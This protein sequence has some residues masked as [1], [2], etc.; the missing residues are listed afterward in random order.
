[1][2]PYAYSSSNELTSKP[3]VTYTYDLNGNTLTSV[4]GSNNTT[5]NWDF[6]NRMTS[7]TLPGTSGSV[8]F[9]YDPMGHRIYKSSSSATSIYAYDGDNLIE[10]TN[11]TGAVVARYTQTQEID[12]PLAMLRSSAT[13]YYHADGLGSVTSLSSAVGALAQT[14]T[15]DSFGKST[16][17]SGSL[18]NPFQF[19]G[20]EFD[21]ESSLYFMRAR[22]F[23][24]ITG[25]F[26]SE[27]PARFPGGINFYTYVENDPVGL[28]DPFGFC[29]WQV[30]SRPLK[31]LPVLPHY[32]FYNTQTGQS[33]GLGPAGGISG[34]TVTGSPVPGGWERNEKPGHNE[35]AVPDGACNCVDQKAKHPGIPPNYCTYQG[36]K[37]ANPHPPCTNCLGWVLSVL[38]DC[39]NQ[40]SAGQQ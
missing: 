4:T 18:T 9:K 30:H 38:Q 11:A 12:E 3:G 28:V 20:R 22:Y 31:G 2:S 35:G 25:R 6:E 16:A 1:M 14:Y 34:G 27:D 5:Y 21:T 24:Q 13:S 23:D 10:E 15:F 39:Y 37:N 7:A 8:T 32:Y 17:S 33:I 36:N 26:I 19:T 29:P 40:A